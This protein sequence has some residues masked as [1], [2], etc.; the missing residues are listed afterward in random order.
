[1][2]RE[3]EFETAP[4]KWYSDFVD[5]SSKYLSVL[6]ERERYQ[7]VAA[8]FS[9]WKTTSK[10]YDSTVFNAFYESGLSRGI[11]PNRFS[12]MIDT[13]WEEKNP[14]LNCSSDLLPCVIE[15]EK[16][17]GKSVGLKFGHYRR[18]TLTQIM[19]L[20]DVSET[21]DVSVLII[22]S[23]E[24]TSRFKTE[25]LELTDKQRQQ[26]IGK[27]SLADYV[28]ITSGVDYSNRYYRDLVKLISP[29]ILYA[30]SGWNKEVLAEYQLRADSV[31]AKLVILPTYGDYST[32]Y[33]EK[34]VFPSNP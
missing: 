27:S 28:G 29:D 21:S 6:N 25:K 9:V 32:T 14:K 18:L 12:Q 7:V 22:E 24:R 15:E 23:G 30:S 19:E 11:D 1:M 31:S 3:F 8:L 5:T 20:T 33:M 10:R 2:F 17:R 13:I 26:M 34:L 16:R 4:E